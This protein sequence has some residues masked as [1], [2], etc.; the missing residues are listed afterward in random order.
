MNKATASGAVPRDV[1]NLSAGTSQG[2][3]KLEPILLAGG[4]TTQTTNVAVTVQ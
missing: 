3:Q 4:G 2:W 1:Q